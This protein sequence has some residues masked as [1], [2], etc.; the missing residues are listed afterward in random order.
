MR[1]STTMESLPTG[2]SDAFSS[3]SLGSSKQPFQTQPPEPPISATYSRFLDDN[4]NVN[5]PS[6]D[7]REK[8][9]EAK[10]YIPPQQLSPAPLIPPSPKL[11]HRWHPTTNPGLSNNHRYKLATTQEG[12]REGNF[13]PYPRIINEPSC[14]W[15]PPL[16][17]T[18]LLNLAAGIKATAGRICEFLKTGADWIP[19]VPP[20]SESESEDDLERGLAR[21]ERG[22]GWKWKGPPPPIFVPMSVLSVF[23]GGQLG[24]G[25]NV[26]GKRGVAGRYREVEDEG[27]DD[28]ALDREVRR[29]KKWKGKGKAV[30]A[31]GNSGRRQGDPGKLPGGT[32][33][34]VKHDRRGTVWQPGGVH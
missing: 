21:R 32:Y 7:I 30:D 6:P 26:V 3:S 22:R 8:D 28:D 11:P 15:L 5:N 10:V 12:E 2:Q 9:T 14:P 20:E 4:H 31:E 34:P 18:A 24:D 13:F 23:Q 19:P 27:S 16:L 33:V 25:I 29:K 1:T 17:V